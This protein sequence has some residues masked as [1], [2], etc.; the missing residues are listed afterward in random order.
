V[1]DLQRCVEQCFRVLKPSGHVL[2]SSG[3]TYAE[4]PLMQQV[5]GGCYDFTRYTLLGHRR[6]FRRFTEIESSA[7]C[8]PGMALA[9]SHRYFLL[10]FTLFHGRQI[11]SALAW[12]TSF[13]LRFFGPF[14]IDKP[15]AL[16]AVSGVYLLGRKSD[17]VLGDR[18]FLRIYKG[19]L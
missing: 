18:E 16:D 1:V 10:S 6:L 9:L 4:T 13:F 3:L 14:L 8:G 7:P 11:V 15:R 17:S 2:K 5:H 12:F 19:L